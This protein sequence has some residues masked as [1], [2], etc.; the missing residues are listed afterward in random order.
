MIMPR[1]EQSMPRVLDHLMPHKF[2]SHASPRGL[3]C[4][5]AKGRGMCSQ[6]AL[7]IGGQ[8]CHPSTWWF[9]KLPDIAYSNLATC[10]AGHML[11]GFIIIRTLSRDSGLGRSWI[12][13]Q[14]AL[15]FGCFSRSFAGSFQVITQRRH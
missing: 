12:S 15:L 4:E 10:L 7:L 1:A 11:V 9:Q 3:V 13:D 14:E 8:P 2:Y 5:N 6:S